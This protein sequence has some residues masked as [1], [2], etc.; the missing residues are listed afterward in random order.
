[1]SKMDAEYF[2]LLVVY[3]IL[4]KFYALCFGSRFYFQRLS[5]YLWNFCLLHCEA[6]TVF[7]VDLVKSLFWFKYSYHPV[8]VVFSQA[9][10]SIIW[11]PE[12]KKYLDFLSAYSAV[13][14]V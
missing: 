9:K 11:D 7:D 1:M 14:Q 12:G 5:A 4:W 6:S 2:N 8:P 3:T 13:N 10:G